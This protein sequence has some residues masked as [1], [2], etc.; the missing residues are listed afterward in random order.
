MWHIYRVRSRVTLYM[1]PGRDS[2]VVIGSAAEVPGHT[3][4]RYT[5]FIDWTPQPPARRAALHR[6]SRYRYRRRSVG[7]SVGRTDGRSGRSAVNGLA[8]ARARIRAVLSI[9]GG[10]GSCVARSADD[11]G[12]NDGGGGGDDDDEGGGGGNDND[13]RRARTRPGSPLTPPPHLSLLRR[14]RAR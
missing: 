13:D 7:R 8:S 1:Y 2:L 14:V 6:E 5:I 12:D 9:S 11:G 4:C 3:P 10:R